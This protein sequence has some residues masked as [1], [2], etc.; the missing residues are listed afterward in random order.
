MYG[1][2]LRLVVF[3]SCALGFGLTMAILNYAQSW[4]QYALTFLGFLLTITLTPIIL[5]FWERAA[6]HKRRFDVFYK[7]AKINV[8]LEHLNRYTAL[9]FVGV[10]ATPVT[11]STLFDNEL[12]VII[13]NA[14]L[15]FTG[16]AILGVY[17]E[18]IR[19]YPTWSR[20]WWVNTLLINLAIANFFTA[21]IER[22]MSVG[23]G[24]TV[25]A[26]VAMYHYFKTK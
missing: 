17:L 23:W 7:W 21:L 11:Y 25:I 20:L 14:H 3:A 1:Q 4:S 5:M 19:Y 12:A 16:L 24:E 6:L 26:A 13:E 15:A 10:L 9:M 2:R 22:H 18:M 8:R